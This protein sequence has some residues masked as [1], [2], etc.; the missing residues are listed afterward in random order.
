[1]VRYNTIRNLGPI[2]PR[3]RSAEVL[4]QSFA[5]GMRL[6]QSAQYMRMQK[7]RME[8]A[9]ENQRK[10][11]LYALTKD[12]PQGFDFGLL[13]DSERKGAEEWL[14]NKKND[15]TKK[16]NRFYWCRHHG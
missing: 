16:K 2:E 14:L 11:H 6:A 9:K 10:Q 12:L 3:D 8:E 7:I 1:M 4:N 15:L 13:H 5:T